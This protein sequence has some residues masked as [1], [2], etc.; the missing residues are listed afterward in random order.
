MKDFTDK[1]IELYNETQPSSS[2]KNVHNEVDFF[3]YQNALWK[4]L[5]TGTELGETLLANGLS[6]LDNY[7]AISFFEIDRLKHNV[8]TG[9]NEGTYR[10]DL[11]TVRKSLLDL[12][13]RYIELSDILGPNKSS[14]IDN[15]QSEFHRFYSTIDENL[16]LE[17]YKAPIS[18]FA[19]KIRKEIEG[20]KIPQAQH[21]FIHLFSLKED[22]YFVI[23][24]LKE[25]DFMRETNSGREWD[26]P[27]DGN[28]TKHYYLSWLPLVLKDFEYDLQQQPFE[29]K[30]TMATMLSNEFNFSLS[31][32]TYGAHYTRYNALPEHHYKKEIIREYSFLKRQK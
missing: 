25:N 28:K 10:N 15:V 4:D 21:M 17:N 27:H 16:Q 18:D 13:A 1:E 3:L 11:K 7:I 31:S 19:L 22:Y 8:L 14:L 5:Y 24:K 20:A 26:P 29:I 9:V 32:K 23:D 6:K 30:K 2:F 12:H